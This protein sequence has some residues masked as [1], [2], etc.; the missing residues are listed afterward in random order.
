MPYSEQEILRDLV[1]ILPSDVAAE[2]HDAWS[3][4][5]QEGAL[6]RIA[7]SLAERQAEVTVLNRTRL[8]ALAEHWGALEALFPT[9]RAI[10][11]SNSEE[12]ARW[13]TVEGTFRAAQ[14]E[15]ELGWEITVEHSLAGRVL[16]AWLAASR[17]DDALVRV[18]PREP[19][20]AGWPAVAYAIVHPTWSGTSEQ[21]TWPAAL[22]FE[23][24][25]D[26]L[27]AFAHRCGT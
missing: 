4:G 6:A 7:D 18:Y 19:W 17:C 8:A 13:E 27:E 10:T 2:V 1:R 22:A 24:V 21:P 14:I 20:G 3:I 15:A 5:E 23:S 25:Y 16:T 9:P 12:D 26:A 11:P